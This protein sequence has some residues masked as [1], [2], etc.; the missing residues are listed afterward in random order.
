ML[1]SLNTE[2]IEEICTI[3][4]KSKMETIRRLRYYFPF[5]LRE[6]S[7]FLDRFN[8]DSGKLR[9]ELLKLAGQ[10]EANASTV[11]TGMTVNISFDKNRTKPA[12]LCMLLAQSF[13]SLE[14]KVSFNEFKECIAKLVQRTFPMADIKDIGRLQE[15][16]YLKYYPEEA[17]QAPDA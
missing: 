1:E 12:E 10:K 5:S 7:D 6:A 14:A 8:G 9:S 13:D 4:C 3:F 2:S 17:A 15:E 11:I 16:I